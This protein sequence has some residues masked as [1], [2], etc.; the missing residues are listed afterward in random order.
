MTGAAASIL[1]SLDERF[2]NDIV[3]GRKTIEVRRRRMHV[4]VGSQVWIYVKQPK[5][6]IVATAT[7]SD[8]HCSSPKS[9]WRRFSRRTGLSQ[10]E[11][12]SY[13]EG[14]SEA[15]ALGLADVRTLRAPMSL[16][17]LRNVEAR[18]HPP[19][20]YARLRAGSP[21]FQALRSA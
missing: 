19:Q 6:E 9:L 11:F 3:A 7:V 18:F 16:S 2:A 8:V 12:L 15:F 5:A 14:T 10:S 20:F 1:I 13:L 4:P 21:I 17:S